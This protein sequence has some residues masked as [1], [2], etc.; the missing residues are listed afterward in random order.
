MTRHL[1]LLFIL[2]IVS[3]SLLFQCANPTTPTGGPRDTIPPILVESAPL[4][5][6]T[7]FNGNRIEMIFNEYV[8]FEQAEEKLIITPTVQSDYKTRWNKERVTIIFEEE[9][10]FKENTTY[11]FNFQDAI[12][13]INEN[14]EWE[15]PR[16]VFSTGDYL[17]SLMIKGRVKDLFTKEAAK[18]GIV[19]LYYSDDTLNVLEDKP[20]YF[21]KIDKEGY[22]S[23][24]N[25]PADTFEVYAIKDA[26]NN[27]MLDAQNEAYDFLTD[28]VLTLNREEDSIF[29]FY[30]NLNINP[31][32]L[33]SAQSIRGNFDL[34]FNKYITSYNIDDP[35]NLPLY[36]NFADDHSKIRIYDLPQP[37]EFDSLQINLQA[38]DSIGNQLDTLIYIKF[39]EYDGPSPQFSQSFKPDNNEA[40]KEKFSGRFE[41]NKPI[42]QINYDSIFFMYDSL[43]ILPLD[44]SDIVF[45]QHKDVANID[46]VLDRDNLPK[47]D[48]TGEVTNKIQFYIAK[49]SF[50][51]VELDSSQSVSRTYSFYDPAN[52]GIIKGNIISDTNSFIIQLLNQ[53]YE[54]ID[55]I[56]N[57]SNY[58]FDKVEPGSYYIRVLFDTNNNGQWDPG[59]LRE[60]QK[61]EPVVFYYDPEANTRV[62]NIKANWEMTDINVEYNPVD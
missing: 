58:I 43:D 18:E 40:I 31:I 10:P 26:N 41:F 7:N 39:D 56:K 44:S 30:Q 36:H 29:F 47:N 34:T 53:Q 4:N 20:I 17:D 37:Y 49:G 23:I 21:T 5:K 50:I 16:F 38:F 33:F 1:I 55:T 32:Q 52:F 48:S 46:I 6:T 8:K 22:F 45:N 25:L 35:P 12:K 62:L 59:N 3:F 11:T 57:N 14:N 60:K 28:P 9:K 42:Y 15:D 19:S 24:E 61:P 54:V 2:L 27:L 13:D 51:S